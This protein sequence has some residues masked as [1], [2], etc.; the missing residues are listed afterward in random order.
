MWYV[1]KCREGQEEI[2]IRSCRQHLSA[3]VLEEAFQFSSR[4][5]KK[6]LGEWHIDTF[7]MFP[8]YVFLQSSHP[9]RLSEELEQF[10]EITSVLEQDRLL[11]PVEKEKEQLFRALCGSGHVLDLSRGSVKNGCF[12][13]VEG[14]LAG[15]ENL[16]RKLDLHKRIA[17]LD[18]RLIGSDRDIWA[19][20]DIKTDIGEAV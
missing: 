4:R 10:R 3:Q 13:A 14:P 12:R 5:M 19:G 18:R 7:Q 2:I 17:V 20:I 16:I 6:Y 9:E 8:G 11:L 1:L 15:R